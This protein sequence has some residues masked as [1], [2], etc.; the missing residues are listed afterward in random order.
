MSMPVPLPASG[1]TDWYG[2][3]Q[4]TDQAARQVSDQA[5][6]LR[7]WTLSEAWRFTA[8]PSVDGNGAYTTGPVAWPDG[9][10]GTYTTT[11]AATGAALGAIDAYTITYAPSGGPTRTVTQAA[12]TRDANGRVTVRPAPAVA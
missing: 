7:A 5:T 10:T 9:V 12:V 3:A 4:Q 11:T 2:W 8:A 1:S 6:R